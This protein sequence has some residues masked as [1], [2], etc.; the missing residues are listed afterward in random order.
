M[1]G[2]E[3]LDA[4]FDEVDE[5]EEEAKKQV[6]PENEGA[7]LTNDDLKPH[8]KETDSQGKTGDNGGEIE[9]SIENPPAKKARLSSNGNGTSVAR[10]TV[11]VSKKAV[12]TSVPPQPPQTKKETVV[13]HITVPTAAPVV[14]P[15]QP[16]LPP[17]PPLPVEKK[18]KLVKR[19]AAGKHWTDNTL[20]DFPDNDYRLFVG[21]LPKDINDAKLAETFSSKYASFVMAR[22]IY[23]KT[24]QTSKGYG[25]VSLLDPRECA[26]AIREMDQSWLG[27]RPIKVKLSEWKDR[28]AKQVQKGKRKNKKNSRW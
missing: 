9:A 27:S 2:D 20:A 6:E 13:H 3:D 11:V 16:P 10:G 5:V 14:L 24:S 1:D 18:N 22:V 17:Q 23:D 25:F 21:N 15:I 28:D 19:A 26:R 7:E 8:S 4:F 12:V